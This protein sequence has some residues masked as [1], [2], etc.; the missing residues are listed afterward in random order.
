MRRD[1]LEHLIR[2]AGAILDEDEVIVVGSQAIL[3]VVDDSR[4]PAEAT[5]SI[6]ADIVPLEDPDETKSTL[7]DGTIGELSPFHSTFGV[8]AQGVGERTARLPVGW[9]DRL[10][11][12]R[13]ENTAG[14]T[15]WCLDP[16]DL[17]VAKLVAGRPKDL[18]FCRELL[19][20]DVFDL[21]VLEERLETVE[22]SSEERPV[23]RQRLDALRRGMRAVEERRA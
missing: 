13:N 21:V 14:V 6:E 23:V 3:G 5:R 10:V 11:P 16:H 22:M 20:V 2:A 17:G 15:G 9:R 8:Y 19:R 4:L 7:I 18:A 12:L 1:Q